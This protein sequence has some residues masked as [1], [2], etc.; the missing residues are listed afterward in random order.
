MD[1]PN[2]E[3]E[4]I[5]TAARRLILF[6]E[7]EFS[8]TPTLQVSDLADLDESVLISS[9]S[10]QKKQ[11]QFSLVRPQEKKATKLTAYTT[12]IICISFY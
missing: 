9:L 1:S 11:G 7:Q 2:P 10:R 6:V 3:A 5:E 8:L 4:K 12:S